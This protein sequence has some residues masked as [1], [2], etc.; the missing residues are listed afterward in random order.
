MNNYVEHEVNIECPK[1]G[2]EW[3]EHMEFDVQNRSTFIQSDWREVVCECDHK[4]EVAGTMEIE[5]DYSIRTKKKA[6]P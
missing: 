5:I 4:F 6:K 3:F 2:C 1:C